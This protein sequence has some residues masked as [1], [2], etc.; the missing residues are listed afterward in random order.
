MPITCMGVC[1]RRCWLCAD[2]SSAPDNH[3]INRSL[4]QNEGGILQ[5]HRSNRSV[6][7]PG[8]CE[9]VACETRGS[10]AASYTFTRCTRHPASRCPSCIGLF[11]ACLLACLPS[12]ACLLGVP[13]HAAD[14]LTCSTCVLVWSNVVLGGHDERTAPYSQG[15]RQPR[16]WFGGVWGHLGLVGLVLHCT[17]DSQIACLFAWPPQPCRLAAWLVCQYMLQIRVLY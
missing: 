17:C 8:M 14:P 16:V 1:C 9:C 15:H 11:C 5:P 12:S 7:L 10:P 13:G 3:E 4:I 2:A 6:V